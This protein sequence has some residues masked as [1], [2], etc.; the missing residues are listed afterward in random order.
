[1]PFFRWAMICAACAPVGPHT[2]RQQRGTRRLQS[3]TGTHVRVRRLRS[4][5]STAP[6][7]LSVPVT[8]T[9]PGGAGS[10][11]SANC[12]ACVQTRL[13]RQAARPCQDTASTLCSSMRVSCRRHPRCVI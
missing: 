9:P 13:R 5:R 8:A 12:R 11:R 7:P 4:I 3:T 6:P 2:A 10:P 1:M